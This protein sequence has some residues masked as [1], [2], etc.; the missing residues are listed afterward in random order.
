MD[1]APALLTKLKY[2]HSFYFMGTLYFLILSANCQSEVQ[3]KTL[4]QKNLTAEKTEK[5]ETIIP[6]S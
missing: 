3:K 4:S 1:G 2:I 6:F 5:Q